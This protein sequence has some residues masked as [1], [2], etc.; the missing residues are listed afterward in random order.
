MN[1]VYLIV[2]ISLVLISCSP[3]SKEHSEESFKNISIE[4]FDHLLK[5]NPG[6]QLVDVRTANEVADVRMEGSVNMDVKSAEFGTMIETLDKDKLV[7]LYCASGVRS[8]R[9][10]ELMKTSGFREVYNLDGGLKA[11]MEVDMP[12]VK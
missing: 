6:V 3:S 9:A 2:F 11:W 7:L 8:G 10:M 5:R 12:V 1:Q 4:E